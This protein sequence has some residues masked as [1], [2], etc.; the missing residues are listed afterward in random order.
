MPA[1]LTTAAADEPI[2]RAEAK[3]HLVIDS[4]DDTH[5]AWIDEAIGE[6]RERVEDLTARQLMP[7]TWTLYLDSFPAAIELPRPP[8]QSVTHIKYI[9]TDGNEQIL[10]D[11]TYIADTNRTPGRIELAYGETW[12]ATRAVSNAVEVC[13]VAGYASAA[14]V[15]KRAKRAIKLL[16]A[17]AFEFRELGVAG[18]TFSPVPET[19]HAILATLRVRTI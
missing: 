19:V 15:P 13:Y 16:T 3:R 14:L 12:P 7:A 18:T 9:D 6:A 10:D 8:L 11:S 17:H 2:T 1:I 4:A 5:D